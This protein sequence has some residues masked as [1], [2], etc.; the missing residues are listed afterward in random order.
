MDSLWGFILSEVVNTALLF[1]ACYQLE[2]LYQ[3]ALE[4]AAGLRFR[5]L[6]P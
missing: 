1:N 5:A 4:Q 2:A 6:H 3:T